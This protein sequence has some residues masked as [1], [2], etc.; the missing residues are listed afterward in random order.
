[1]AAHYVDVTEMEFDNL[2]KNDKGWTKEIYG[3]EYL[4]S[5]QTKKNPDIL[6]K[7]YSSVTKN[8]VGKKCGGDAIRICAVN[9]KTQRGIMKAKRVYR[10]PGWEERVK[11]RVIEI[12]N[13]IW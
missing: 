11:E 12:L 2:L 4:Y 3:S 6:V 5:F 8:G 13:N 9:T 10:T 7:V 1:M